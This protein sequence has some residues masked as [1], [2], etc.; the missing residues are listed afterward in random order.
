MRYGAT[1]RQHRKMLHQYLGKQNADN[2]RKVMI[3][4]TEK[5][6][7]TLASKPEGFLDATRRWGFKRGLEL[8]S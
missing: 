4:E 1:W 8:H 3:E 5:Y 2:Y 7:Q 6:L